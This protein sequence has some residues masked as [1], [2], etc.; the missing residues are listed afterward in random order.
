MINKEKVNDLLKKNKE[1]G[2]QPRNVKELAKKLGVTRQA[3]YEAYKGNAKHVE[4]KLK[5]WIATQEKNVWGKLELF[6]H[7]DKLNLL[8]TK[9]HFTNHSWYYESEKFQTNNFEYSY[10]VDSEEL[11]LCILIS[12]DEQFP[13]LNCD[14]IEFVDWVKLDEIYEKLAIDELIGIDSIIYDLIVD[15]IVY[16]KKA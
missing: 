5:Q 12:N 8:E 14:Q 3:L 10:F 13:K 2:V 4:F 7:E 16:K 15:G 9:Y 6:I 11:K 1:I